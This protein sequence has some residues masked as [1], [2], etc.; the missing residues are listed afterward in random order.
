MEESGIKGV[1]CTIDDIY[2]LPE[3]ERAELIEGKIYY[4]EPPSSEHQRISYFIVRKISDYIDRE[5]GD[6]EVFLAPFT[7]FLYEDDRNYVEPDISVICE[8]S[9]L[10]DK[11]CNGAPDWIIEIVSM[12]SRKMD[13]DARQIRSLPGYFMRIG[14]LEPGFLKLSLKI[15]A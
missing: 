1:S 13:Y 3:G 15:F 9:K 8:K 12:G 5:K 14:I 11:G 7:V 10:E 4:M 2:A 6:C